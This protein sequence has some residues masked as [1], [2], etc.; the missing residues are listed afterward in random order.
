MSGTL[1]T[2]AEEYLQCSFRGVPFVVLGSGGQAG[3]K[4]A[5]HDYPY[6]DGVWTEDLGRRA[7]MY[8][9]RG[10]VCGPEYMAQRD[11]LINAA[12]A[13]DSGLLVHPTLGILRVTLS[14]FSWMEPDGIMGRIDVDFDFLEQKN[15]LSTIIQT[16]LDAAIGASA[17]AAQMVG[18]TTYSGAVTSS[19]SVGSPV[20]SAAQSV[21]GGWGSLAS[22]AIRSPRVN[23]AAIATLPGNNGRYAAGNAGTI[24]STATVDSVLQNL[25]ASRTKI[26]SLIANAQEQTTAA[27]L[28]DA[29]LNV[30][31]QLRQSINDPG[32]QISVLLP[33]ATYKIDVT[34]SSAPIGSAI[35]TASTSTAQIC[36]WMAFTSIALACASWQPTSAE[37]AENLRLRVATLLDNAATEAADAGL[38]DMWRALRSLRVQVTTDL[39]QRASQLPDQITVTRNAPVPAL[40]LGQQLY[41]DASRAPDLIRRADPIHPAFMPTQFEALSS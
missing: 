1:T 40:V 32:T 29:V 10:F 31:E 17:L 22:S 38:D 25:T 8:H 12:E 13:A 20:I 18:S 15:Y 30:T 5:V 6:R 35:A 7:R 19:L 28:A 2:L 27:S 4:Q 24:D 26:D 14:N 21:V 11:L 36:C 37:E 3:R 23:S 34:S 39:S 9:V 16:S 41:A 33:M